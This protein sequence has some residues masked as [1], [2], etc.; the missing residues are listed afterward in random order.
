MKRVKKIK[1]SIIKKK[2]NKSKLAFKKLKNSNH[3]GY[4]GFNRRRDD[5]PDKVGDEGP[6]IS[7]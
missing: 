4:K 5:K 6:G 3:C 1:R 2:T 7:A